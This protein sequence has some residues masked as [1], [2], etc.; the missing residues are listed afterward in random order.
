MGDLDDDALLL[1]KR[2]RKVPM[3]QSMDGN[4]NPDSA[5]SNYKREVVHRSDDF[6]VAPASIMD[7]TL[8]FNIPR[9]TPA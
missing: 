4:A 7:S 2:R 3:K 5:I 9:P 8:T 6:S 1:V